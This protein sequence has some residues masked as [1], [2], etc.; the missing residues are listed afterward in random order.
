MTNITDLVARLSEIAE[1][2]PDAE[3]LLAHQPSWPLQFTIAGVATSDEISEDEDDDDEPQEERPLVVYICEGS[4]P[5][6]PYAPRDVWDA[7]WV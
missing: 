6:H 5:D 2:H 3:V 1:D 4:H 7:A